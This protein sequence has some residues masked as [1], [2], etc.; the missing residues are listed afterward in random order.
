MLVTVYCIALKE[1]EQNYMILFN[2][3]KC[4][5]AIGAKPWLIDCKSY[6]HLGRLSASLNTLFI[7]SLKKALPWSPWEDTY[8]PLQFLE[9]GLELTFK[10]LV[11]VLKI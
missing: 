9:Q 11:L 4:F 8:K 5:L 6:I 2:A 1:S 10:Y 3:A 7:L